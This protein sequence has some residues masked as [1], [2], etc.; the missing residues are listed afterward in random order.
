MLEICIKGSEL[1]DEANEMFVDIP[2]TI[3]RL[4]HS[5]ISLSKWEAKWHKPFLKTF[6][7]L[8]SLTPEEWISYLQCMT[9][10]PN[11]GGQVYVGITRKQ[12]R[13]IYDYINDPMTATWFSDQKKQQK[14]PRSGKTVTAEL[15][16]FKMAYFGIPFECEKLHLNRLMTLI[17]VCEE[18]E[19]PPKKM[20]RKDAAISNTRLNAA[21]RK[22]LGTRG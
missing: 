9:I 7:D 22:R 13:E 5:L 11:V 2:A 3:L 8:D 19:P 18:M 4:E 1:W 20:G 21:R 6:A 17:R 15:I 10:G 14:S 12:T 16:Y